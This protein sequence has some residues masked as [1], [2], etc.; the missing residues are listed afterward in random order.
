MTPAALFVSLV[1]NFN[2]AVPLQ[3]CAL[4]GLWIGQ[5]RDANAVGMWLEFAEDGSVV[6][7]N[8]R[9]VDGDYQ[10]KGD[11]LTLTSMTGRG[12]TGIRGEI[13]Q[14]V[15]VKIAG[16]EYSRTAEPAVMEIAKEERT[17]GRRRTSSN[18]DESELPKAE[19]AI[20]ML[21]KHSLQRVL[22]AAPGQQP[23][24]GV[25]GYKNKAGRTVLERYSANRRFAVLEPLAGQRGTF[26]VEANKLAVTADGSTMA[27]PIACMPDAFELDVNGTKM[28]FV[29]FQ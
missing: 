22:Q 21:E 2:P 11:T 19:P 14:K 23:I 15:A 27:V 8:G 3:A 5:D 26:K 16:D 10:L 25:W 9:I 29:K 24:V 20:S 28:R 7:A 1:L 13:T 6:R 4:P 12:K 17:S 18:P